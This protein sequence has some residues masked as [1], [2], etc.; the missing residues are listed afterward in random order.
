[1]VNKCI[2]YIALP[3]LYL[4]SFFAKGQE[5]IVSRI[6]TKSDSIVVLKNVL[7]PALMKADSMY[8][9]ISLPLDTVRS[10]KVKNIKRA[11]KL[12]IDPLNSKR[13][14]SSVTQQKF[15]SLSNDL[16]L[17]QTKC[18]ELPG[19]EQKISDHVEFKVPGCDTL[20]S[21]ENTIKE[22]VNEIQSASKKLGVGP[23]EED[24]KTN[25]NTPIPGISTGNNIPELN[26][27]DVTS[28]LPNGSVG[29]LRNPTGQLP[30]E[31]R[32]LQ[33]KADQLS[34]VAQQAGELS[35]N[36]DEYGNEIKTIKE[37]GLTK[38]EKLP[39][40]AEKQLAE[41]EEVKAIQNE[42]A[43]AINKE[44][45]Y[46]KLIEQYKNEKKIEAELKEKARDQATDLF[47]KHKGKVDDT[48]KKITKYSRKFPQ[49]QDMREL[50]KRV[51]NPLK[52]LSW[53]ERLVPGLSVSTLTYNTSWLEIDPQ[54]YYR[55]HSRWS[56]GV[57]GMY[58]F[59]VDPKKV[60]FDD[61]NHLKG[62][63]VF[64]Q[65]RAFKSFFLQ[66]EGQYVS[67]KPWDM[68][69]IDPDFTEQTYVA[70]AGIGKS[71]NITRKLKGN[72]TTLYHHHW[73]GSDPY[74][75][76]VLIR[77]GIDLSLKKKE[78]KPWE[79]KVKELKK[80]ESKAK[81]E[82][83]SQSRKVSNSESLHGIQPTSPH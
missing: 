22:R 13:S 32:D 44:E 69:A 68:K 75:S 72:A 21:I 3:V 52:E 5:L 35:K 15:D 56:A 34:E 41:I 48:M 39:D 82:M 79:L 28:N 83:R 45:E 14:L 31:V 76:K 11:L 7:Q 38:S 65:Y 12:R 10:N 81:R 62:G 61:F 71:F 53:R 18:H 70:A 9:S 60:R 49:V 57:G 6:E 19:L 73:N 77:I 30:S 59:S 78:V 47:V 2:Y 51:P 66:A 29:D 23:L 40:L 46:R 42:I 54:V 74:R 43:P 8:E 80:V 55:I 50:P 26:T 16:A 67:W 24:L 4:A 63:K 64:V 27:P 1:M 20:S 37:E 25:I 17:S 33:S 58:R 36:V